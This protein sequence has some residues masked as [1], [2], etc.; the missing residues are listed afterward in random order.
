MTVTLQELE[1]FRLKAI[2][3]FNVAS[4]HLNYFYVEDPLNLGNSLAGYL[5][6]HPI[7]FYGSLF[8]FEINNT[9]LSEP[10]IVIG[11]PKLHYPFFSKDNHRVYIWP[12]NWTEF[13]AME[14]WDGTNVL[15]YCY[16]DPSSP[17]KFF[18]TAKLRLYP[19]LRNG[20]WGRFLDLWKEA[21][22]KQSKELNSLDYSES[23]ELV[24]SKNPHLIEYNFPI[25]AIPLFKMKRATGNICEILT[26]SYCDP[27]ERIPN[28]PGI[29]ITKFYNDRREALDCCLR[30]E[31]IDNNVRFLL[32]SKEGNI[33]Y[34]KTKDSPYFT[35]WKL[36]PPQI[37]DIHWQ[38]DII[39]EESII[40]TFL[41]ILESHD[42]SYLTEDLLI[43]FLKEE[44]SD[45]TI[46]KS[47]LRIQSI[48]KKEYQ[49]FMFYEKVSA[50]LEQYPKNFLKQP[51]KIILVALSD[52]FPKKEM[53][54]VFHAVSYLKKVNGINE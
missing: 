9:I 42:L 39:S 14:K 23:Y 48:Y 28:V 36:K 19:V 7:R 30:K 47:L 10:W 24:G 45:T 41:N 1:D 37:E 52:R 20:T 6:A 25:R 51:M 26:A 38:S 34:I 27:I 3:A 22:E 5:C 11:T 2:K 53:R 49:R 12:E 4:T 21:N 16:P 29:D 35:L 43:E 33:F 46:K 17:G 50:M 32:G 54:S 18:T 44:F 31:E 8:I 13:V 40:A 15:K